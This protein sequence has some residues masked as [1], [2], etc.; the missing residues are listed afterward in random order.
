M[1]QQGGFGKRGANSGKSALPNSARKAAGAVRRPVATAQAVGIDEGLRAFMLSVYNYMTAGMAV[2]GLTAF[3][4]YALTVTTD[5]TR[6]AM[7]EDGIPAQVTDTEYLTDLGM[8]LWGTP[9]F[10]V[11]AFGP[12]ALLVF[13]S[14]IWRKAQPAVAMAVFMAVAVL[15]GISF[16]ALAL[17]YTNASLTQMFFATAT[18][19]GA[20]SLWGYTTGKDLSGWGSFLC[21]GLFGLIALCIFNLFAGSNAIQFAICAMGMLIFS[22]FTA[23]DTQKIKESYSERMNSDELKQ[24]AIS[25]ALDLYLDFVNLFRFMLYFFGQEE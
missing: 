22:G 11:V 20:L 8:L 2:T 14:G 9:L 1:N 12:L 18:G 24:L 3:G 21:M 17:T 6:A 10:Y 19:F 13:T 4:T 16:S 23:Y 25:G 5:A 7:I 15:I